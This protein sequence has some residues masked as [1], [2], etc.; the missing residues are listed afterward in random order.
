MCVLKALFRGIIKSASTFWMNDNND[1]DDDDDADA[2]AA[3]VAADVN[4]VEIS[5]NHF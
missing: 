3:A 2:E 1:D 4:V 5:L